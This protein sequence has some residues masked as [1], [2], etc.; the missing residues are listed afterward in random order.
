MAIELDA[1]QSHLL[2][3]GPV[4]DEANGMHSKKKHGEMAKPNMVLNTRL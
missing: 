1:Y 2:S 3:H 4:D